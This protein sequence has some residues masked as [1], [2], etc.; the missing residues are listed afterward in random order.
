[1]VGM[2]DG[3]M[4]MQQLETDVQTVLHEVATALRGW[5]E[6]HPRATFAELEAVVDEQ[7]NRVRARLLE[8]AI[9]TSPVTH[10]ADLPAE[11]RSQ[12]PT[13][14]VALEAGSQQ[15]RTVI[16]QGDQPVHIRRSYA[17]C[18]RCGAGLFPPG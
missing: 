3:A 13:C 12:C 18:P 8:E 10:V 16:V 15:T 1:M 7:V 2:G 6:A 17:V 4:E 14:A 9:H 11:E 5:R